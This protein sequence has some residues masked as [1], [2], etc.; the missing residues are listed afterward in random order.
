ML[1]RLRR[2]TGQA[3]QQ[4]VDALARL[5]RRRAQ[6]QQFGV[7]GLQELGERLALVGLL[8][9][10]GAQCR[11]G[12][13]G[14]L[15]GLGRVL[16]VAGQAAPEVFEFGLGARAAFAQ[17]AALGFD[18]LQPRAQGVTLAMQLARALDQL[19]DAGGELV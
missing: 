10:A 7:A 4:R 15:Q 17:G 11:L 18:G 8:F 6:P 9:E 3:D 14:L 19:P 5:G 12:I 16:F 13:A 2:R 1:L